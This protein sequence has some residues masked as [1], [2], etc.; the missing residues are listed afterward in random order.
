MKKILT[1]CFYVFATCVYGYAQQVSTPTPDGGSFYFIDAF[2]KKV[3]AYNALTGKWDAQIFGGNA[4]EID[5]ISSKDS[6]AFKDNFNK[7]VCAFSLGWTCIP[8]SG[9]GDDIVIQSYNGNFVFKDE[10]N[11]KA[12]AFSAKTNTW[13][14]MPYSGNDDDIIINSPDTT[15]N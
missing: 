15:N 10:F 4:S 9:S 12:N 2:N 7:K 6:Y 1:T 3:N 8:Y 5:V 13:S 11:N 14:S